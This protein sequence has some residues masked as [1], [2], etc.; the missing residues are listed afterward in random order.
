MSIDVLIGV[1]SAIT[2]FFI[3][4]VFGIKYCI[5]N[6]HNQAVSELIDIIDKEYGNG[7]TLYLYEKYIIKQK[8][9]KLN[10]KIN[11]KVKESTGIR[12]GSWMKWM[13]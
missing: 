2:G 10:K 11:K 6:V 8:S 7:T 9:R 13:E 3:G 4:T 1:T 12:D 5:K